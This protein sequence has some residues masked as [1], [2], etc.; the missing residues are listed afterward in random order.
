MV[1]SRAMRCVFAGWI[2]GC[3]TNTR[4]N[5]SFTQLEDGLGRAEVLLEPLEAAG[6]RPALDRVVGGDVGA[7]EAVDRLLRIADDEQA[8]GLRHELAPVALGAGWRA[9]PGDQLG[10]D[11]IGVLEL[12]DQDVGGA[13][14]EVLAHD[15]VVA[16]QVARADQQVVEVGVALPATLVGVAEH[17]TLDVDEH[18]AERFRSQRVAQGDGAALPQLASR[19]P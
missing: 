9:D 4:S 8:P 16:H 6:Q 11:R 5:S 12:V 19:C 7:A 18:V 15:R 1:V 14:A 2:P 3:S 10:L 17:E 13:P